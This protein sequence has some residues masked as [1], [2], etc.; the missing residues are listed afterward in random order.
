MTKCFLEDLQN[1]FFFTFSTR[2]IINMYLINISYKV[3]VEQVEPYFEPHI[4]FVRK[5]VASDIFLLTAKKVPRSGGILL[6][7]V[8]T[9]EELEKI[10][11][12]DP[13][14]EFDLAEFQVQ[15]IQLSQVSGKLAEL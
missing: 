1:L 6:A 13:F 9:K 10:L 15:E 2:Q 8:G 5:Y 3:P 11:Q 14:R 12:E 7:N 4:A